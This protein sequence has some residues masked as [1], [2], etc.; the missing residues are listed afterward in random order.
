MRALAE[1]GW[2]V[3]AASE[4]VG[5]T[6]WPASVEAVRLDREDDAQLAAASVTARRA[7]RHGGVR[8]R[9]ARQ[10]TGLG[11]R[12]GS[13]VAISTGAVYEDD[14]G[15]GFE[16]SGP[17]GPPCYPVPIPESL[18][19]VAPGDATNS[20]RKIDLERELLES[21]LPRRCCGP[22]RST[23]PTAGAR[24]NSTS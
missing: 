21:A 20:T 3:R 14:Q 1:D 11:D 2:S 9:H 8:E 17:A 16:T 12:I 10:L 22:A 15:R 23:A 13:V 7:G 19:T 5:R 4:A 6:A 24:V 18:G